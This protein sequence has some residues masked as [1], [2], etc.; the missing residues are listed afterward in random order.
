MLRSKSGAFNENANEQIIEQFKDR[1]Q[2]L[3]EQNKRL[4]VK[5]QKQ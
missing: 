4:G 3:T 2:Q 1:I 5:L